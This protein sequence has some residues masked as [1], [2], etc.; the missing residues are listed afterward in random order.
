[1]STNALVGSYTKDWTG[2]WN[3]LT[4]SGGDYYNYRDNGCISGTG[5]GYTGTIYYFKS[6][7]SDIG[8]EDELNIRVT[9][10]NYWDNLVSVARLT[11]SGS[12]NLMKHQLISGVR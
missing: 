7:G 12:G 9:N 3:L 5:L 11:V 6:N 2:Q 1:M 8:V 4:G 10:I